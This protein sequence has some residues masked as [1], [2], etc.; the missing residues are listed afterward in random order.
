[1]L[2]KHVNNLYKIRREHRTRHDIVMGG[3]EKFNRGIIIP[4]E[5]KNLFIQRRNSRNK[6]KG[7]GKPQR[8]Y[9]VNKIFRS[10]NIQ[11]D[12]IFHLVKWQ[13]FFKSDNMLY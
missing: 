3:Q 7:Y 5:L 6:I 8:Y 11:R 13:K 1:M 9:Q 2:S 4:V 12:T 10:K